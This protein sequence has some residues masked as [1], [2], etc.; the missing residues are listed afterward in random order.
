MKCNMNEQY[1]PGILVKGTPMQLISRTFSLFCAGFNPDVRLMPKW[2]EFTKLERSLESRFSLI[3]GLRS[4][5]VG[6]I[7]GRPGD[8]LDGGRRVL[9]LTQL[10]ERALRRRL[11][12]QHRS[13]D[14]EQQQSAEN[15]I[16]TPE[17][18]PYT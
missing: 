18:Y 1:V 6:G 9:A 10:V 13:P 15:L 14:E 2:V 11:A 17:R 16:R 4:V 3:I 7:G 12:S 5:P 8:V